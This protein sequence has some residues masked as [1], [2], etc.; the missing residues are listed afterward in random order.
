MHR[1]N[2]YDNCDLTMDIFSLTPSISEYCSTLTAIPKDSFN[3]ELVDTTETSFPR[4][5]E[6]NPYAYNNHV[7]IEKAE[8]V[9]MRPNI[10]EYAWA[11]IYCYYK[12]NEPF[13]IRDNGHIYFPTELHL[14]SLIQRALF[15][16]NVG[17]ASYKKAFICHIF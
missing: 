3:F 1:V 16:S 15:I 13:I 12:R 11:N 5:R 8:G 7:F 14:P 2:Q 4:I 9:F 17:F 10:R 6:D